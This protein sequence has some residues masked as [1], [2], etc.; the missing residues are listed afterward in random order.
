MDWPKIF[1]TWGESYGWLPEDV[2]NRLTVP[3]LWLMFSQSS[4]SRPVDMQWLHEERN[5]QRRKKGLPP[6]PFIPPKR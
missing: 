5:R 2:M 6:I 3:Q 4:T 1:K